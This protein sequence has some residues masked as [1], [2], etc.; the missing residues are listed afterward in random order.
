MLAEFSVAPLGRERGLS[1]DVARVERL[2]AASGLPHQLH[3][4]GT[5]I[6]G[7]AEAVF[8]LV[9]RCHAKMRRHHRRVVT[10]LKIDD[11]EGREGMLREKVASVEARLDQGR[12]P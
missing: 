10:Y 4:M 12:S 6:E 1:A 8:D 9:Q 2:V 11:C 5:L 7:S 3:A